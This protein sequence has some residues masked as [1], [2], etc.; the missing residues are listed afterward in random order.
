MKRALAILAVVV[1]ATLSGP[2]LANGWHHG[3]GWHGGPRVS[4]GFNFGAP[5][6][7]PYYSPYYYYP[8]P[9][10]YPTAP[11]YYPAAPVVQQAAPVY[12]ERGDVV[13]EGAGS[14]YFCRESNAY[15]PYVKQCAGGWTRV[16]ARPSN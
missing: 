14:W 16:P 15:Y 12:V 9:V 8:A 10:Y 1:S 4:F 3:G 6:Y 13:P 7:G 2:V 5:F 11:V